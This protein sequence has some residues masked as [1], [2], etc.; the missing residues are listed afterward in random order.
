MIKE[1]LID[2]LYLG[3]NVNVFFFQSNTPSI[4]MK[5][6]NPVLNYTFAITQKINLKEKIN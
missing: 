2:V 1:S 4:R 3:N 6:K 5:G